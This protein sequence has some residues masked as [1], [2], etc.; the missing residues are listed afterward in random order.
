MLRL[1]PAVIACILPLGASR[2]QDVSKDWN[3]IMTEAAWD[4][5]PGDL[6]FL[7]G[8]NEFDELVR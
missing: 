8:V 5:R 6:V 4:W 3:A 1:V 2:A 7:N